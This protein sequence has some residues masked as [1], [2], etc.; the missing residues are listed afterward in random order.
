MYRGLIT[1][2]DSQYSSVHTIK[3]HLAFSW[4]SFIKHILLIYI[5]IFAAI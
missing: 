5:I 1:R 2:L 4:L 3:E